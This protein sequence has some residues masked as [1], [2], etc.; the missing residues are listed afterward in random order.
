MY[1]GWHASGIG[2]TELLNCYVII[3]L[4]VVKIDEFSCLDR[5]EGIITKHSKVQGSFGR[6]SFILYYKVILVLALENKVTQRAAMH[7]L[8]LLV[9]HILNA[10]AYCYN[11]NLIMY[12]P[13]VL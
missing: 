12:V 13:L 11:N 1:I 6:L 7:R 5:R 4:N 8:V 3:F 9:Y 2:L 10:F